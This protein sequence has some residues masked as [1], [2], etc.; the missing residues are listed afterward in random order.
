LVISIVNLERGETPAEKQ[1]RE[2]VDNDI[3]TARQTNQRALEIAAEA[4]LRELRDL[5]QIR[6]ELETSQRVGADSEELRE[7]VA[8]IAAINAEILPF[9]SEQSKQHV[10]PPAG[11]AGFD[12]ADY[13]RALPT[14]PQRRQL[15]ERT[16]G[17]ER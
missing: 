16:G 4:R 12:L 13:Q 6:L 14:P 11:D 1:Q 7:V 2:A 15:E 10:L 5:E 9:S 3:L 17:E 8:R